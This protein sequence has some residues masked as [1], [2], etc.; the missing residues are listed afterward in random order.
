M[1]NHQKRLSAPSSWP[2]GKT[3]ETFTISVDG[4]PHGED[5]IP[6][7]IVLRD[8]LEYANSRKEVK[9][10][11]NNR[12][13]LINGERVTDEN[14]PVGIFDTIGFPQREEYYRIIPSPEEKV[15]FSKTDRIS[16]NNKIGK[17]TNK[18]KVKGGDTQLTLHDGHTIRVDDDRKF[19]TKDSVVVNNNN[20]LSHFAYEEGAEVVVTE[21]EHIGEVGEIQ[22]IETM[23]GSNPNE[24]L[25]LGDKGH[26]FRT[27]EEYV[28][29]VNESY[30]DLQGRLVLEGMTESELDENLSYYAHLF[31]LVTNGYESDELKENGNL[32][33]GDF[34]RDV[35][36]DISKLHATIEQEKLR[37]RHKERFTEQFAEVFSDIVE[38]NVGEGLDREEKEELAETIKTDMA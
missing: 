35:V 4:G 13:V 11:L 23:P 7:L 1:T 25:V 15:T 33:G 29:P 6:L 31:A 3:T 2:I 38:E 36:S 22:D 20:I 37:E 18:Q 26:L 16:S 24:V 17:I 27:I 5:G 14:R 34:D 9:Y 30:N 19:G 32:L 21:G 8:I 10:I 28:S 12:G